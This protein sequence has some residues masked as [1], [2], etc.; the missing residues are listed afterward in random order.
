MKPGRSLP[1]TDTSRRASGDFH[2][3]Q[4]HS[5][6][7]VMKPLVIMNEVMRQVTHWA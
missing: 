2:W 7:L 6:P 5:A 4:V 1:Q 3:L